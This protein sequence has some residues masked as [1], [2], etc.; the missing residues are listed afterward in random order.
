MTLLKSFL[1][2]PKSGHN[3]SFFSPNIAENCT[4][5]NR[6]AIGVHGQHEE[7]V[8]DSQSTYREDGSPRTQEN[9]FPKAYCKSYNLGGMNAPTRPSEARPLKTQITKTTIKQEILEVMTWP[10]RRRSTLMLRSIKG[11]I[12]ISHKQ[13]RTGDRCS[14]MMQMWP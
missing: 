13:P 8:A 4:I 5:P 11:G 6:D 10:S 1:N 9:T 7:R 14:K 3:N 12:K 2:T